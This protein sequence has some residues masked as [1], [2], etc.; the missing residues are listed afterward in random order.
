MTQVIIQAIKQSY[1]FYTHS[2]LKKRMKKSKLK[3]GFAPIEKK[4]RLVI[5]NGLSQNQAKDKK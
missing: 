3:L 1:T 4:K 5:I 2:A